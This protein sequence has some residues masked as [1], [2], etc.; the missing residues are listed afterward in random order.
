MLAQL[1]YLVGV[2]STT[3]ISSWPAYGCAV[4]GFADETTWAFVLTT[5]I[6]TGVPLA[7]FG[8]IYWYLKNHTMSEAN[9]KS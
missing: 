4:C 6:L 9:R 3:L 7:L 1:W 5:V 2:L 8:V